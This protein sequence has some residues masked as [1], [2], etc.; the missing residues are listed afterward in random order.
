MLSFS[1][2]WPKLLWA[3]VCLL[4]ASV[5]CGQAEKTGEPGTS[6]KTYRVAILV[7]SSMYLSLS[8]AGLEEGLE[9]LGY[10]H[11]KNIEYSVFDGQGDLAKLKS[12]A[13]AIVESRP[14]VICPS[15][16]VAVDAVRETKTDL[17]VVFLESMYP[18]E[19]G[20]AKSLARPGAN[21]TGVTNMTGPM[22]GK[23]LELLAT[24]VPGITR[25]ALICNPENQVS[26]LSLETTR[27][28]A[29][30]LGLQL[31][32]YLVYKPEDVDEAIAKVAVSRAEGLVL[33][34]DYM[35][36]SRLAKIVAM[37][38]RKKIP[39][40]GIDDSQAA[41]GI[42]ASYGGGLK[43]IAQQAAGHVD[44]IL[45]GGSPAVIPIEPPHR[46]KLSVNMKT[47]EEIGVALPEEILHQA[48]DYYR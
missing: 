33:N 24:M 5:G 13:A 41:R 11:G 39:T 20:L 32:V 43:D 15:T 48:A 37:A 1:R 40:M 6:G 28:A 31:D 8:A 36:F 23:R 17:P 14:D 46:Y 45:R 38:R 47:A 35:V 4:P 34:P 12:Q 27:E 7:P 44:K 29:E 21:Y 2:Q 19:F 3:V 22:S 16:I 9:E 30:R 26:R 10:R 25:V 18:V 42:L